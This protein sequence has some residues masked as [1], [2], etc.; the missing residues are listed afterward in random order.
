MFKT[1]KS[2]KKLQENDRNLAGEWEGTCL[3]QDWLGYSFQ[4]QVLRF[5]SIGD[6]DR[7]TALFTDEL[8]QDAVGTLAEQ[9][10]YAVLG[11][12]KVV[13]GATDINLTISA[14]NVR[15]QSVKS[16]EDFNE[17][18]YCGFND[19]QQNQVRDVLGRECDG[20]SHANGE[21]VFD[22]YRIDN[23]TLLTGKGSIFENLGEATGR[24]TAL[25]PKKTF[26]RK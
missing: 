6:F 24:P 25:D 5:S 1:E 11:A 10:T 2:G 17:R 12:S 8:C 4:R 21:V 18:Q 15:P 23:S 19:W 7:S 9:G 22:I 20:V 13:A 14:A 3:Q 26:A 16:V